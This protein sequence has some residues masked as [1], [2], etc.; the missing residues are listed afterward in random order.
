MNHVTTRKSDAAAR[1]APASGAPLA[2]FFRLIPQCRLPM[3]ADRA[4]AGT[5]PTRAFRY[6]EAMTSASAYGWYVFPPITFSLLWDGGSDIFWTYKG[7]DAWFPLG[8]AQ[9]PG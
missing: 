8:T 9:F 3:R 5:M 7:E 1:E 4:A 6:C 2:T